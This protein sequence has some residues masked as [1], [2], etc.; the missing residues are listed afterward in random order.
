MKSANAHQTAGSRRPPEVALP[1]LLAGEPPPAAA[2]DGLPDMAFLSRADRART[3][4]LAGD[5]CRALLGL[6]GEPF[7]LAPLIHPDDREMVLDA[8]AIAVAGLQSFTVEYRVRDAHGRWHV[9]W[10]QGRPL[11]QGENI[12]LQGCLMDVTQRL[13]HER[14]R[15]TAEHERLQNQKTFALNKLAGGIAHEFNNIIA[16]IL[17]SA[18]LVAMDLPPGNV[19]MHDSLKQIFSASNRARDFVQKIRALAQRPP[20]ERKLIPLAPVIEDCLQ[21]LRTIVPEKMEI[22]AHLATGCPDVLADTASLQAALLDLCLCA[23]Q[24]LPERRGRLE[25]LLAH[26]PR[27]RDADGAARSLRSGP[28][29]AL[30][31][32]DNGPGLD[33]NSLGKIFDPFHSRKATGKQLGLEMFLVRETI[34]AHQ[35]EIIVDSAPE[36]GTSFHIYLPVA[37]ED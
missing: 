31:V 35:G 29:L 20:L 22:V 19:Q 4:E 15:L 2:P 8:V 13:R 17:G 37:G 30:T 1:S 26:H 16:G 11:P 14:A 21:I 3:V 32:R 6:P 27:G 7:E 18:E 28:H 36:K 5:G 23:W 9:V 24:G 34:H 25:I 33:K 10:E 12:F